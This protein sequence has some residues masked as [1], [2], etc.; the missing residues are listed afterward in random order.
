MSLGEIERPRREEDRQERGH[1]SELLF[2]VAPVR[3]ERL[4]GAVRGAPRD[5]REVVLDRADAGVL[6]VGPPRPVRGTGLGT[7][8]MRALAD[9]ARAA[10]FS[11]LSLS[12]DA[13]NPARRL[14][15]RLGYREISVDSSGVR[16]VL[17]L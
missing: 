9:A 8:L 12:V 2:V 16:I 4:L 17:D 14:Y 11:S 3:G 13:D 5:G 15:E 10:G 7:R 6:E 1:A